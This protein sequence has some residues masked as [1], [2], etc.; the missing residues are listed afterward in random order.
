MDEPTTI[1]AICDRCY[2]VHL[3]SE[4][5]QIDGEPTGSL[6]P[7]CASNDRDPLD[8]IAAVRDLCAR[9]TGPRAGS[10]IGC[11]SRWRSAVGSAVG[12]DDEGIGARTGQQ[13]GVEG[14]C[15]DSRF[16]NWT[17]M[18]EIFPE[19]TMAKFGTISTKFAKFLEGLP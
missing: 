3:V 9:A 19:T 4:L 14:V 5:C 12:G 11:L 6:C 16:R 1:Q 17:A 18:Q 10:N 7:D 13:P 8:T 15:D 2:A